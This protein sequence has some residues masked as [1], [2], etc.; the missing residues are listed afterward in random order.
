MAK[1]LE[2]A[3]R[4]LT[5]MLKIFAHETPQSRARSSSPV[6]ILSAEEDDHQS[7]R[8]RSPSPISKRFKQ[9]TLSFKRSYNNASSKS[10]INWPFYHHVQGCR[11][12]CCKHEA[13]KYFHR[14][15]KF[16]RLHWSSSKI[17]DTK[18]LDSC[19]NSNQEGK[20]GPSKCI[21]FD[22]GKTCPWLF[23]EENEIVMARINS[24]K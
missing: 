21:H 8:S 5:L 19:D 17:P 12:W 24:N 16:G 6:S 15:L 1:E 20:T 13:H 4:R 18:T 22:Y 7:K 11:D 9:S 3:S 10:R 14:V 23:H 2:H